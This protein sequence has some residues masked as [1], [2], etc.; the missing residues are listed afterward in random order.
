MLLA[1]IHWVLF[2]HNGDWNTRKFD[3]FNI[4]RQCLPRKPV[5]PTTKIFFVAAMCMYNNANLFLR[6]FAFS[7]KKQHRNNNYPYIF[8]ASHFF[9]VKKLEEPKSHVCSHWLAASKSQKEKGAEC[10]RQLL[11]MCCIKL[12]LHH[13]ICKTHPWDVLQWFTTGNK[14]NFNLAGWHNMRLPC[15]RAVCQAHHISADSKTYEKRSKK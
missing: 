2:K 3:C 7:P 12:L 11:L 15:G 5:P 1:C 9:R 10:K 14:N 8:L 4:Y 6:L 13:H